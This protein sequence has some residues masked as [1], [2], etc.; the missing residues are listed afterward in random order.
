MKMELTTESVDLINASKII[1]ETLNERRKEV[2]TEGEASALILLE[3][4]T[5]TIEKAVQ[6]KEEIVI[7]INYGLAIYL[8]KIGEYEGYAKV[9]NSEG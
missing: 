4:L 5:K 6:D 8:K 3:K 9:N 7:K 2:W 1:E